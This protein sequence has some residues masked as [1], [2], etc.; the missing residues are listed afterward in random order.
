MNVGPMRE[1]G[2]DTHNKPSD[3]LASIS[4][5]GGNVLWTLQ[6]IDL[7]PMMI[8]PITATTTA[9]GDDKRRIRRG[10]IA[11]KIDHKLAAVDESFHG[12]LN[13]YDVVMDLRT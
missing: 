1:K 8:E 12:E 9:S 11:Q 13:D 2:Q 5:A 6:E 4:Q 3:R 10:K 7:S